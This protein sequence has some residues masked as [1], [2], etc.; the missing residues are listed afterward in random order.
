[1][2]WLKN[3]I[4]NFK[5]KRNRAKAPKTL[6]DAIDHLHDMLD[7]DQKM[8]LKIGKVEPTHV[9]HGFGTWLRNNWGLWS[10]SPLRDYFFDLGL[11]HAD[12]MSS[13]IL[14]AFVADLKGEEFYIEKEVKFYRNWWKNTN[15]IDCDEEIKKLRENK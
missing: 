10:G 6:N 3:Q 7:S 8:E 4:T 5:L 13:I 9:H 1:M 12:D 15:G 14:N 11:H 2:K